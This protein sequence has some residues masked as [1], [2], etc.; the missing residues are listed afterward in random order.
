MI[1]F[2]IGNGESRK[3]IDINRL[4]NHGKVIGCNAIYRDHQPDQLVTAD[5]DMAMEIFSS[6]YIDDHKVF[7]PYRDIKKLHKNFV[8]ITDRKRFCAGI[9]ACLIALDD[10]A[11]RIYLVGHDLGSINGLVNNCYK[12]TPCYK[13]NWEDDDS[14]DIHIP[15]YISLIKSYRGIEFVRVMGKVSRGVAG[16]DNLSNYSEI[17]MSDFKSNFNL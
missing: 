12:N 13:K 16:L 15:Q 8:L 7:T 5:P 9:K 11:S 6:T 3:G 2:V 14:A 4:K 17:S 10:H 1:A